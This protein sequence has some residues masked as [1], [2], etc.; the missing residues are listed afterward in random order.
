MTIRA[1]YELY[2]EPTSSVLSNIPILKIK[3][4]PTTNGTLMN[5]YGIV[6]NYLLIKFKNV[7]NNVPYNTQVKNNKKKCN[8][9]NNKK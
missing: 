2:Q 6:Y 7:N 5:L 8:K 3:N 4:P 1:T 9:R